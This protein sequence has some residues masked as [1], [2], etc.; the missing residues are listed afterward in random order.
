MSLFVAG[1]D[2]GVGKTVVSALLLARFGG[3]L[4]LGYWKPIATGA[5]DERDRTTVEYLVSGA[6]T[7]AES[8]LFEDPVSPHLAARRDG[9][10][11]E[12]DRIVQRF[13]ELTLAVARRSW[14]VEGAGG[15]LV[16]LDERGTMLADLIRQL[17]LPVLLVGRSTLG[18]INQTL[19]SLEALRAR[20][21]PIAGV[22]LSGPPN[23]DNREAI[24]RF[25]NVRV[26]L[27][28]PRFEPLDLPTALTDES[29]LLDETAL[30]D[31][32]SPAHP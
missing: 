1:T 7:A 3:E 5:A 17:A 30:R 31:L 4:N 22:A 21:V 26:L 2:T 32:L 6:I 27:E 18:T 19:L 8:Y 11:I 13:R 12:V 23:A 29:T 9:L 16:P 14:V 28:L 15:L 24:E 20:K 10:P 25:G